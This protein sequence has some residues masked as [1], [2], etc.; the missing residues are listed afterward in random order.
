MPVING[1]GQF[2]AFVS[3]SSD[4]TPDQVTP[5]GQH[6]F[7]HDRT[8]KTTELV[9]VDSA[10]PSLSADGR[11]VA[12]A[13]A[14][15]VQDIFIYDRS[16]GTTQ[17]ITNGSYC[18]WPSISATGNVVA[19]PC[20]NDNVVPGDTHQGFDVFAFDAKTMT[21]GLVSVSSAGLQGE[22]DSWVWGSGSTFLSANG[23]YV[24][25]MSGA[26]LAEGVRGQYTE[27]FIRDRNESKTYWASEGARVQWNALNSSNP[28]ISGNGGVVAFEAGLNAFI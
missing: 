24:V 28:S 25:F 16:T 26:I 3:F 8:T 14:V 7:V 22:G 6:V 2:V 27:I 4:L 10:F 13:N 18:T 15:G 19:F 11:F 20:W 1:T 17:R 21:T 9:S 12:Y 23:R 5:G